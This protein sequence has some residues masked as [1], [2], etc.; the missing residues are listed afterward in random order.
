MDDVKLELFI[1]EWEKM[2]LLIIV[3]DDVIEIEYIVD[4]FLKVR[5]KYGFEKVIVDNYRIDIVRCVFEDVGIKFEVFRNLKVIYGLFVLCI[6][7]MFVKYNVIYGDNFLMCWFINNVVVKVKFD[8]NKEYIKK[9][10]NRRKIDGFMV[11]VYVLYRV[12]DIV[13]KDMFKVFDV[14]MS[15]DF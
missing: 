4:W 11:F 2:G 10:E 15:I 3:D 5:E 12:D 14:L 7:I 9:D 6:D 1:K 13:D 8:G